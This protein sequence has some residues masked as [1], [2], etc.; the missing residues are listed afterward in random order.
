MVPGGKDQPGCGCCRAGG[1]IKMV[2][3]VGN[4]V[5]ETIS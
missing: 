4:D 1:K 5:L 3:R 2:G